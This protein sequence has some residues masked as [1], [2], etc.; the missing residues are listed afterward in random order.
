MALVKGTNSY[1]TVIEADAYF[2]NRIDAAAYDSAPE[3]NKIKALITATS[4]LDNYEYAGQA[5]SSTQ[6]L[7]FPRIG[8]YYDPTLGMTIAFT[9][10]LPTRIIRATCELAYHLLNNDGILD[11]TGD[12]ESLVV[13]SIELQHIKS[14]AKMLPLI[15]NLIKPM[16]INSGSSPWWRSN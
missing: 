3:E 10:K 11:S 16:R 15:L 9:S 14:P 5:I 6:S 4:M 2:L 7:A 8:S 12:V 13:G 1:V